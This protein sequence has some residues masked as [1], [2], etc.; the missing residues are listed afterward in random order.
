MAFIFINKAPILL[1]D[2]PFTAL[3]NDAV[4][5]IENAIKNHTKNGGICIFTTHQKCNLVTTKNISI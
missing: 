4:L 3:D 2:E 5:I 1:L